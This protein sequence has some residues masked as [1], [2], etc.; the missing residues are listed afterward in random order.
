MTPELADPTFAVFRR[1]LALRDR[2]AAG[3]R[4]NLAK[5]QAEFKGLL[6]GNAAPPWGSSGGRAGHPADPAADFLGVRYALTC[7]LD[8]VMINAGWAEWEANGLEFALY[9]SNLRYSNF[10]TQARLAE[11]AA[12][13][14]DAH[15][16]FL[17]CVLLGFRGEMEHTPDNLREWVSVAR[18]RAVRHGGKEP[19]A[20]PEKAPPTDPPPLYGEGAYRTAV[21]RLVV[22]GLAA[23]P[24]LAF[25][26]VVLSRQPPA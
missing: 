7:W 21:R 14:P 16:A 6:G 10:W 5:A 11:T 23:V 3:D 26:L 13:G 19:A 8:E 9:R 22:V 18:A 2:L 25:L 1:G 12:G 20:L 24:V 17:W 4:P 15:E